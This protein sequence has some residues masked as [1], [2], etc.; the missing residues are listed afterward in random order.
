MRF[1]RFQSGG[2]TSWGALDDTTVHDLS[3]LPGPEPTLDD[4]SN[5]NRVR[6]LA[7]TVERGQCDTYDV[8][9]VSLL[10][11]VSTP[12]KL[13]CVGL[14]YRDHAEEADR[15]I[16]EEPLLFSKAPT[17]VTNPESPVVA[18]DEV[19]QLDY[20]VELALVI[21]RYARNVSAADAE[22]YIAGYTI[23]NDVSARDTQ[24]SNDEQFFLG[25]SYDTFA[26]L[27][28]AL[29]STVDYDPNN[30]DIEMRV[31]GELRQSSN[32]SEFIFDVYDLV[33]FLSHRLTLR[34]G[35]VISTGT[36]SG[37][38]LFYDPPKLL[39]PGHTCDATVEG[40]GTL[41]NTVVEE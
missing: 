7:R 19:T 35:D 37:V 4:I 13:V 25:K 22:E 2:T 15:D 39:E 33:E 12:G 14:N 27:G 18:P 34:P 26:P 6:E 23:L 11:P 16:P 24:L 32:T 8:S 1:V 38:G 40:I 9:E 36:T 30:V 31:N 5:E 3:T 17:C 41:T 10:A 21:G 20:E 29:R 28:P